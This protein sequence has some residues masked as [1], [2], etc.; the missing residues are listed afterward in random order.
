MHVGE[1]GTTLRQQY[2]STLTVKV[3]PTPVVG[4]PV[5]TMGMG[6]K[7]NRTVKRRGPEIRWAM[8]S[9]ARGPAVEPETG[10]RA[11]GLDEGKFALPISAAMWDGRLYFGR[12]HIFERS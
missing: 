7:A 11:S 6:A 9:C 3:H 1:K 4:Q 5:K 10:D 8:N 2:K 12:T